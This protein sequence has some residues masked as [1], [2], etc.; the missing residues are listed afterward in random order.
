MK[1]IIAILSILAVLACFVPVDA[2]NN[3]VQQGDVLDLAWSSVA[4]TAG[5]PVIKGTATAS[6]AVCGVALKTGT[7]STYVPVA[8]KG[9]VD[10]P[11]QAITNPIAIGDYIYTTLTNINTCTASCTNTNTGYVFGKS[12]ETLIVASGT[13]TI[14]VLLLNR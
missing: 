3:F 11:V 8:I 1:N 13:Q 14:K 4:P 2:A 6:G 7:T 9:V 10:I 5:D 12:L